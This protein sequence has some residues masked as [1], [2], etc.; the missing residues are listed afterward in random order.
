M[1]LTCP[2]CAT[3]YFVED[4]RLGASGRT[5]RCAACGQSWRAH[6][7]EPLELTASSEEGAV[8]RGAGDPLSFRPP[9]AQSFA[10]SPLSE[11]PADELPRAIRA[12]A[13]QQRRMRRAATAGVVW[14]VMGA[15][16][17]L[18]FGAAYL[19]RVDV[20][21]LYP[22][23]AG[24]YAMAGLPVNPTGLQFEKVAANAAPDGL[25]AI[26][27]T[28]GV[29]NVESQTARTPPIRVSLLDKNG[30]RISSQVV[31]LSQ[32]S[33]APGQAAALS[34][35]LPDPKGATAGVGLDFALDLMPRPAPA[36]ARAAPIA[37]PP[38]PAA[39]ASRLRPALGAEAITAEEA[40]P[41]SPDT[42]TTLDSGAH[43][44]VSAARH[45]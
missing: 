33:I 39:P 21:K 2:E 19:F 5:V 27:V 16:F 13:E 32:A 14:G 12:K 20:V 41:I 42:S 45:G 7:E 4:M 15:C 31:R 35:S 28:A 38:A 10:D 26:L 40:K 29:R 1:I 44:A 22:K 8:A 6:F 11:V 3:R 25:Q 18:L 24:A 23:A 36:K 9:E 43:K 17:A 37:H 30:Q 34:V